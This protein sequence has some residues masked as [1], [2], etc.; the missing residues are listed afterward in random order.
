MTEQARLTAEERERL[1]D[2]AKSGSPRPWRWYK[3]GILDANGKEVVGDYTEGFVRPE[4]K[5]LTISAVN[6]T[7]H[8]LSALEQAEQENARLRERVAQLERHNDYLHDLLRRLVPPME[9]LLH[10]SGHG[11]VDRLL[12]ELD[13]L[14]SQHG[15]GAQEGEDAR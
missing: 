6:A 4:D 13:A 3:Y 1:K 5:K 10:I 7:D 11:D 14:L 8:L 15:Q 9:T 12:D 2:L